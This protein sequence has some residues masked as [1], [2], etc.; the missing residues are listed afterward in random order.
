MS[1]KK[2]AMAL[3][4]GTAAACIAQSSTNA[5]G[6][7]IKH[8]RLTFVVANIQDKSAPQ[9]FSLDVPVIDGRDGISRISMVSGITGDAQGGTQ[10]TF[11]CSGVHTSA[12]GLAVTI[13]MDSDREATVSGDLPAR[14]RHGRFQRNV[15]LVLGTPTVVT[16]EMHVIPLGNTDYATAVANLPPAPQI[17]VT[18][19]EL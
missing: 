12:T 17:T 19:I 8:Y 6:K 15:D 11:E 4:L 16:N 5:P 14:H 7:Q 3:V 10:Q 9:T 2:L 18:A 13:A 1:T